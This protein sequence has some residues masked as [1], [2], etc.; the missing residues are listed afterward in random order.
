MAKQSTPAVRAP[1]HTNLRAA[2]PLFISQAAINVGL[3]ERLLSLAVGLTVVLLAVRRFL[4]SAGLIMAGAYLL[5]RGL[6]GYCPLY[7]SEAIDTRHQ[8]WQLPEFPNLRKVLALPP[9]ATIWR[10]P[11][12][13]YANRSENHEQDNSTRQMATIAW[14]P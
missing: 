14:Q 8:Q 7:A 10:Q 9:R 1:A 6:T 11:F 5:Y 13:R 3:L 12:A 4:L 2:F